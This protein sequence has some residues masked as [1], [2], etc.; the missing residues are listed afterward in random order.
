M[1][2]GRKILS[3]LMTFIFTFIT[4]LNSMTVQAAQNHGVVPIVDYVKAPDLEYT[5][6]DI[7]NFDLHAL[8]YGGRVQYRVVLWK[9]NKKEARDLWTIGDR[10]YSNWMP[11]GN[12]TF[13]LHWRIDEP[14][15][16]RITVYVKRAGL[17]NSKTALKGQNCDSYM[18][19][20]AFVVKVA[21]AFDK[22]GQA[23]GSTE[24]NKV[25]TYKDDINITAKNVTLSNAKLEGNLII[26]GDNG[27]IKNVN[28]L[29]KIV[30]DPGKDGVCTLDNVTAKEIEVLSGGQSSI[31]IINSSAETMN[32]K[33]QS[34]V[35]IEVDGDTEILSTTARGYVIFD[36]KNG[37]YGTITITRDEKGETVVE[38]RG[39]IKDK[40][41]VETAA[42][43]KTG[44]GSSIAN[45]VINTKNKMDT[46]RL[47][48]NYRNVEIN[49][50]AKLEIAANTKVGNIIAHNDVEIRLDDTA[51]ITNVEKNNNKVVIIGKG[52]TGSVIPST[53]GSGGSGGYIPP[54]VSV[55]NIS[56]TGAGGASTVIDGQTLQMSAAVTPANANNKSVTWTVTSGTGTATISSSGLLTGTGVGTATVKATNAASGISGSMVV[57][58]V[59]KIPLLI[60]EPKLTL[61]KV[62][63]GN[64][65]AVVSVGTLI[66][67]LP[68]DD[69]TVSAAASYDSASVGTGKTIRVV[70]TL[71]G[72][73]AANYTKPVDYIVTTGIITSVAPSIGSVAANNGNLTIILAAKPLTAPVVGDFTA[74]ININSGGANALTL[75]DFLYDGDKTVTYTFTPLAKVL[76]N[77]NVV[78]AVKSGEGTPVVAGA[79]T[80]QAIPAM[81]GTVTITGI[82]K[83]S[84][85]LT[86]AASLTNAGTPIYQWNRDGVS[87]PGAT[88]TMYTLTE[89]DIGKTI[90]VTITADGIAG[91]GSITSSG[92]GAVGKADVAAPSPPILENRYTT[93]IMLKAYAWQ[94]FSMD[95]GITWRDSSYFDG[96]TEGTTYT[97]VTRVK[98]TATTSA[99]EASVG[100]AVKTLIKLA[101][102]AIAGVTAPITGAAPVSTIAATAEY[103]A[104]IAWTPAD[105]ILAGHTAYTAIIT[106]TPNPGYTLAGISKDFFTVA[107]AIAANAAGS[108]IV[109][110]VFPVTGAVTAPVLSGVTVTDDNLS[111]DKTNIILPVL[112]AGAAKFIYVLSSDNNTVPTPD[113]M[114][115]WTA[116]A[117]NT[118]IPGQNLVTIS[119]GKNVGIAA[120]T[121]ANLVVQFVNVVAVTEASPKIAAVDFHDQT[122]GTGFGDEV[123]DAIRITFSKTMLPIYNVNAADI[124]GL[125][126]FSSPIID[127][128]NFDYVTLNIFFSNPTTLIITISSADLPTTNVITAGNGEMVNYGYTTGKLTDLAG[129][130]VNGTITGS[131]LI[132]GTY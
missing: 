56:V 61:S 66:G 14:G 33:S 101:T 40:I 60:I 79:F 82:K 64:T 20:Q 36:R 100:T 73:D 70:Y 31:H 96:L 126:F 97:F 99:S 92:T 69:V 123:G 78:I 12:N 113:Y 114:D 118:L 24:V 13:N 112:P 80:V 47:E 84:E 124:E 5:A 2:N 41:E 98:E 19:S 121:A 127:G 75:S 11:F 89:A 71:S 59:P 52:S 22:D 65:T 62:Y 129:S 67:V 55:S 106:I 23:Y 16:Y 111:D 57:T 38:F 42:A 3:L 104:A 26:T 34:T 87:I 117:S 88:G 72:A 4:L 95:G 37:T 120:V 115:D 130:N 108:G 18:E 15:S 44:Q 28:V 81:T 30:I 77:Q 74:T 27:V 6:G 32:V 128:N 63:D 116:N 110:A 29:G 122:P 119:N 107:G 25:E 68:G 50:N 53:G 1:S 86:A 94:E 109:T 125:L 35:R 83:F 39:D 43:I 48:G 51:S 131:P 8:N 105:A 54:T 103:T 10:Y 46:V 49:G 21:A 7:V 90:T 91:T 93:S 76:V 102:P 132:I 58:V 17:S 85:T 45:L 9:D